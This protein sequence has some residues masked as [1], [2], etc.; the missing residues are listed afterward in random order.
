MRSLVLGLGILFECLG[1]EGQETWAYC[2]SLGLPP[3][4]RALF[5]LQAFCVYW[6]LEAFL[7][8]PFSMASRK[9]GSQRLICAPKRMSPAITT[10]RRLVAMTHGCEC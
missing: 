2:H 7:H 1:A 9:S 5:R 3:A 4:Q 8:A 6:V 10:T